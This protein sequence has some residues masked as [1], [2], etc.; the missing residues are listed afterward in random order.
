MEDSKLIYEP[1]LEE[2]RDFDPDK[3]TLFVPAEH[4]DY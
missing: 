3:E 4:I 2:A 1:I